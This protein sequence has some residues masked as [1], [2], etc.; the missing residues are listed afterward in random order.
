[1][2][3]VADR[4]E[5]HIGV[6]FYIFITLLIGGVATASAVVTW[7]AGNPV[8]ALLS[9]LIFVFHIGLYWL[10]LRQFQDRHW[11]IFYYA[12]QSVLII[13]LV[14]FPYGVDIGP[15]IAATLTITQVGEGL[16]LWGNTRRAFWLGLFYFGLL[17]LL[18][19]QMVAPDQLLGS[20]SGILINGGF[21]VLVMVVY[22]QR[23][24]EQRKA[25]E[26][27]E[28][29]ES[30]NAQL[31]AYAAKNAALT[32]QTERQRMARELH[33]TLAQGVAGLILQLEAVKAH[34]AAGRS[35]RASGIVEQALA[36]A[37]ST[38]ADS[39]AAIDDLRA[40]GATFDAAVHDKVERFTQATGIPCT[41]DLAAYEEHVVASDVTSHALRVLSEALA[42]VTRHAQATQVTVRLSIGGG[43]FTLVV[44]DNGRGFDAAEAPGAGHYGLLGMRERARLT[45]GSITI[46]SAVGQ[47]TRV[48]FVAPVENREGS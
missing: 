40:T 1:M 20:L 28:T 15:T 34:L 29:L 42:N 14:Q 39:R 45:G 27:A 22:N 44:C 8:P 5:K 37:R 6:P 21:I 9:S 26:L 12:A 18:I 13:V 32:L 43:E 31:A 48:C 4:N 17:S 25:L 35:E 41:L 33:D 30:A 23:L 36:R 47:G 10:N 46:E 3:S 2:Q 16:G 19:V 24:A 38:L 7:R 11:W